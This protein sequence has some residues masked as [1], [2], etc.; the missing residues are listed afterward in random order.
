M[1]FCPGCRTEYVT[2]V[3]RCSDCDLD[4]VDTLLQSEAEPDSKLVM[5]ATFPNAA[6]ASLVLELLENNGIEAVLRGDVD[7]LGNVV[8]A[9]APALLVAEPDLS[10]AE[11]IY[12]AYFAGDASDVAPAPEGEPEEPDQDAP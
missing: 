3:L 7:P 6:E 2:G 10:R 1:P 8:V 12:R 9:V 11:E 5:L 4:L